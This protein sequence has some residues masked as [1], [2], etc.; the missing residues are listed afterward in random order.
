MAI[1]L[2]HLALFVGLAVLSDLTGAQIHVAML[3]VGTITL[4]FLAG[5]VVRKKVGE[6]AT[7]GTVL[8]IIGCGLGV[9]ITVFIISLYQ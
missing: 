2:F 1:V 6:L 8:I 9:A 3:L 7:F 4:A 5:A